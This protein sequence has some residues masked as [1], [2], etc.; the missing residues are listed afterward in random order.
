MKPLKK[1]IEFGALA[2]LILCAVVT[3]LLSAGSGSSGME[4]QAVLSAGSGETTAST[5][6]VTEQV[7]QILEERWLD[8]TALPIS[9]YNGTLNWV[10]STDGVGEE[11]IGYTLAQF[12]AEE[13]VNPVAVFWVLVSEGMFEKETDTSGTM[14]VQR[15][16]LPG[17]EEGPEQYEYTA[18]G[19]RRLLTELLKLSREAEDEMRLEQELLGWF[20]FIPG[21]KVFYSAEEACYYSYG[22]CYGK[23][24]AHF[25]CFYLRGDAEGKW[26]DDVEFQLLN[27]YYIRAEDSVRE[28]LELRGDRQAQVLMAAAELLMTGQSALFQEEVPF[29]YEVG[30]YRASIERFHFTG[31]GEEGS[32]TNYRL[33]K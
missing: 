6:S 23:R 18:E 3:L 26:I 1:R 21:D 19:A 28:E 22:I 14:A 9:V 10:R 29:G 5:V 12:C 27:L 15:F 7:E 4:P 30:D 17:P 31:N 32:L 11:S 24:T 33:R 25:L 16:E 2:V 20:S 13:R 8:E